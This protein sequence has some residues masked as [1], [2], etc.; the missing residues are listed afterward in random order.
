MQI[1]YAK[2]NYYFYFYSFYLIVKKYKTYMHL[3][4]KSIF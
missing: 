1:N 2:K 3:I 4:L